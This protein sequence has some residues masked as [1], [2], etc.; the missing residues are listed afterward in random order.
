MANRTAYGVIWAILLTSTARAAGETVTSRPADRTVE[1]VYPNLASGA[2]QQARLI[3]LSEGILLR[4]GDLEITQR[5]LS[6]ELKSARPEL[7]KQLERNAFFLL[8]QVAT[9]Q[10][11][12]KAAKEKMPESQPSEAPQDDEQIIKRYLDRVAEKIKVSDDEVKEFYEANKD[13]CGGAT[14]DQ[15]KDE[16]SQYVLEQKRQEAAVQHIRTLGNR[17]SVEVDAGWTEQQAKLAMDNPVDKARASGKPTMV[18]FGAV[19]CRACDMMTP[20][21]KT[22]EK[23]YEGKANI[24]FVH[25]REEQILAARYGIRGIP[26]QV[27]FDKDG[28]EVFRHSGFY[29]Q[30][31]IEK[32]LVDLEAK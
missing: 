27:F 25:V 15:I 9:P 11:L 16:L 8:E 5:D 3:P 13:M 14:L 4:C 20:I 10:L 22:L 31:E 24:L 28:K 17:L 26:G 23:K 19:G 12:M 30:M 6:K 32:Q 18:D 29:P 7:A 2:L 1:G 21:L